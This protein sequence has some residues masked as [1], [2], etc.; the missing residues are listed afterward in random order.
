[1]QRCARL[2][3]GVPVE[4]RDLDL[5]SLPPHKASLWAPVI[6]EPVPEHAVGEMAIRRAGLIGGMWVMGYDVARRPDEELV[7][8]I[9]EEAQRRIISLTGATTFEG[10]V[11]KQLNALKRASSLINKRVTGEAL[12]DAEAAEVAQLQALE[13]AVD[14]IRERSNEL[15]KTLPVDFTNDGHWA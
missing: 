5:A 1:M 4:F 6:S 8:M 3:D 7:R 13:A 15:E 11:T 2:Q 12:T 10:S 14:H 9:K